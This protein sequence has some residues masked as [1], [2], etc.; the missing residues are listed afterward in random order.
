[1]NS[2]G[3][4]VSAETLDVVRRDGSDKSKYRQFA[5]EPSGHKELIRWI[6]VDDDPVVV[7]EATG[8]YYL[9]LA[10]SL[11]RAG[12]RIMIA[13]PRRT[14]AFMRAC[15]ANIQTDKTD[16][17][18][19][20][21]FGQRM[22]FMAWTRPSEAAY[23]LYRIGRAIARITKENTRIRNRIHAETFA[24]GTPM[25]IVKQLKKQLALLEEQIE[26]LRA[27]AI[28]QLKQDAVW[29]GRYELLQT[30]KGIAAVSALALISE[31]IM[32]PEDLSAKQWV[33]YAGLDPSRKQSGT[34]VLTRTTIAKT[35]NARLRAALYMPSLVASKHD[36]A[37]AQFKKRLC[38]NHKTPLQAVVAVQRKLL[39]G[40]HAMFRTNKPWDPNLLFPSAPER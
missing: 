23:G 26:E 18:L 1:M 31:L 12:I 22:P 21:M 15:G 16:A 24:S 33:K 38:D 13:N 36:P 40:I 5:N 6:K 17:A 19:L 2:F 25:L 27:E 4:D 10:F 32:L 20:A 9:E 11:S 29:A 39:H 34:S 7:M 28:V 30:M 37:V 35:G 3:I 8:V 14:K